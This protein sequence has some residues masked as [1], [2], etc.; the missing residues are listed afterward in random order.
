MKTPA[1][2]LLEL[3]SNRV[4][5]RVESKVADAHAHASKAVTDALRAEAD[6]RATVRR[7]NR[8]PSL[9]AGLARLDELL[10]DLTGPSSRSLDGVLR[11]AR[12]AFYLDSVAFWLPRVPETLLVRPGAGPTASGV[13]DARRLVLH[14][15]DPRREIGGPVHDAQHRLTP[16]VVLAGSRSTSTKAG[17]DLL[18][19]WERSTRE[20]I[21]RACL[22][23]L[24]DD[25]VALARIAGRDLIHPDHLDDNPIEV[26]A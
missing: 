10:T 26:G 18:D 4:S 11:D 12:Q 16:A 25:R 21:T 2:P 15:Y 19:A 20:S 13:A 9:R 6:G 24:G 22:L 7:A 23:A 8:S 5:A 17:V 1:D 3:W 14:G